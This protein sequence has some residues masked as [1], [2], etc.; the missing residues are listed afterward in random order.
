MT[1]KRRRRGVN[2]TEVHRALI[3]RAAMGRER[4]AAGTEVRVG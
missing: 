4:A 2:L 1:D 3:D